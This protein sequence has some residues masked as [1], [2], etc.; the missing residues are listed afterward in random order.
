MEDENDVN[1]LHGK[2]KATLVSLQSLVGNLYWKRQTRLDNY[3][4]IIENLLLRH[5]RHGCNL[6][7]Y[8]N[9]LYSY[10]DSL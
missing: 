4:A 8:T 9:F 6:S 3:Q 10:V 1:I 5:K 7:L 2:E